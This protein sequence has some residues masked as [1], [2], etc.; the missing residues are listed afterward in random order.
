QNAVLASMGPVGCSIARRL[1][2]DNKRACL[3][4][5]ALLLAPAAAYI[6]LRE[7]HPEALTAPFLLLMLQARVT[8]SFGRH[9]LWFAAVL[10]CKATMAPLLAA[11]CATFSILARDRTF[12]E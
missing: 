1:G 12:A 2:F 7:F 9:W 8:K 3:L 10:A 11:Y 5:V 6:A 4:G